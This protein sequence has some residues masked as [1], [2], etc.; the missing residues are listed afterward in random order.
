MMSKSLN[1][2]VFGSS[3]AIGKEFTNYFLKAYH[4]NKIFSFSRSETN[5]NNGKIMEKYINYDDEDTI[6]EAANFVK[7]NSTLDIVII[8]SGILYEDNIM[9]EKSLRDLTLKN[10]QR[11][12]LINT[13]F[14]ALIAKYFIPLMNKEKKSVFAILSAKVGS[15][16]DNYLGGWY[17]YRAS[18]SALNMIIKNISIEV[19]RKS[20]NII[21][22]G[23]HPGTV[24]SKLSE[25]FQSNIKNNKI[26][27]PQYSV[28]KMLEIIENAD[29]SYSGKCW[30][31]DE[32][33]I[34]P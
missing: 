15:I 10:F 32:S 13:I 21:V 27:S 28:Q 4:I 1:I 7:K 23:L 2:A 30:S 6:I 14:P 3:G 24:D 20:N 22:I 11:L 9:P 31:W 25:P 34:K 5:F 18:K 12:F 8:A 26:F 16:S 19:K 17:S 29:E 33:E